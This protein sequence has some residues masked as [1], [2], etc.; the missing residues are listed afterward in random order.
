MTNGEAISAV[1]REPDAHKP[2]LSNTGALIVNRVI[3][4][5]TAY[6]SSKR[7]A[8]QHLHAFKQ[9]T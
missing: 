1:R 3:A 2:P 5:Q 6:V 8:I 9:S 7:R 4:F